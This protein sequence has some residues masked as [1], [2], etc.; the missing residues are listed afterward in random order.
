MSFFGKKK[1]EYEEASKNLSK[2]ELA[3]DRIIMEQ[4]NDDDERAAELVKRLKK[5]DPLVL[6][7]ENLE[8][9]AANK[10]LAFFAGATYAL[11]GK[12]VMI[13]EKTYLFALKVSFMDGS[14]Q[15]FLQNL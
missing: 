3:C 11:D 1:N 2:E 6:N 7:F 5:G 4:I 13:N 14:L 12:S 8:P 9:M 10:L 15:E